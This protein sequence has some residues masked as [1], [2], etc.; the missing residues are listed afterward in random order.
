MDSRDSC[1]VTSLVTEVGFEPTPPKRLHQT[2]NDNVISLEKFWQLDN[3]DRYYFVVD[4]AVQISFSCYN[5]ETYEFLVNILSDLSFRNSELLKLRKF[6][7]MI[8]TPLMYHQF[9]LY[10]QEKTLSFKPIFYTNQ[11]QNTGRILKAVMGELD[12][13]DDKTNFTSNLVIMLR[14][15]PTA[16][17]ENLENHWTAFNAAKC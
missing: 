12:Q 2:M 8:M 15:T 11:F 9:S 10:R 5:V 6:W 14:H 4:R 7:R 13:I 1:I 16:T 17:R 3:N